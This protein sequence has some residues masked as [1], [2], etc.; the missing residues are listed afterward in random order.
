MVA[1]EPPGSQ[2]SDDLLPQIPIGRVMAGRAPQSVL[3]ANRRVAAGTSGREASTASRS[4]MPSAPPRVDSVSVAAAV[5]NATAAASDTPLTRL[6]RNPA[7]KAAPAPTA[8]WTSLT[9]TGTAAC[10]MT[11]PS[12]DTSEP[13]AP[14][15]TTTMR[16]PAA[17]VGAQVRD[18]VGLGEQ[19]VQLALVTQEDVAYGED[20]CHVPQPGSRVVIKR[21][22]WV[23]RRKDP[24]LLRQREALGEPAMPHVRKVEQPAGMDEVRKGLARSDERRPLRPG[25]EAWQAVRHGTFLAAEEHHVDGD[26]GLPGHFLK[27][28]RR[29]AGVD[30]AAS[31]VLPERVVADVAVQ[32]DRC[33]ES[34][35]ARGVPCRARRGPC[36]GA[37]LG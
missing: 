8:S 11:P 9:G 13:A 33:P 4:A 14:R 16:G 6:S 2:A 27:E 22:L 26:G 15:L 20:V 25:F 29:D 30:E 34:P 28:A 19:H 35:G 31:D 10:S 18:E 37:R 32:L 36:S 7:S 24:G 17:R 5:P 12:P 21:E 3:V 23:D 1:Q